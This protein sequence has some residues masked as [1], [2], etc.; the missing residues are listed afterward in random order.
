[1]RQLIVGVLMISW[2]LIATACVGPLQ[3]CGEET[4][5]HPKAA[6]FDPSALKQEQVAG[7]SAVVGF[8]LEGYT[9]QVSRSLA[10]ALNQT[11]VPSNPWRPTM[12]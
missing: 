11:R 2:L 6:S 8:G 9:H 7:L 3:Q 12:R 4:T 5:F 10:S 1:M